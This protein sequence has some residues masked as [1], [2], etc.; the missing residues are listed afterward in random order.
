MLYFVFSKDQLP[1]LSKTP[2]ILV[3]CTVWLLL[4]VTVL[5]TPWSA[6]FHQAGRAASLESELSA[7]KRELADSQK[8][9][10]RVKSQKRQ[11]LGQL[12]GEAGQLAERCAELERQLAERA[13]TAALEAE[14]D[15]LVQGG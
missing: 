15:R 14:R 3:K 8:M 10:F 4:P 13:D 12:E 2:C 6:R 9:V 7:V 11:R 1:T 5:L